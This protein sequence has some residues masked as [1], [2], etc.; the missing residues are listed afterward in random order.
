MNIMLRVLTK[1]SDEI[2]STSMLGYTQCMICHA[3]TPSDVSEDKDLNGD[4][5]LLLAI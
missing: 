3:G 1:V 5:L 4:P 2:N